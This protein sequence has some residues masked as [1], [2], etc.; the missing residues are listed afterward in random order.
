[1]IPPTL[2]AIFWLITGEGASR[3]GMVTA[4]V[5]VS[6]RQ[7]TVGSGMIKSEAGSTL[8]RIVGG[9]EG[10]NGYIYPAIGG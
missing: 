2:A 7:F 8:G 3:G 4:A 5:T 6:G 1:M 10:R 9:S